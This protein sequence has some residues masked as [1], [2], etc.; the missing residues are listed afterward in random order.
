M[1]ND[2]AAYPDRNAGKIS[3]GY[4]DR[5]TRILTRSQLHCR[6]RKCGQFQF[7]VASIE[8]MDWIFIKRGINWEIVDTQ[9]IDQRLQYIRAWFLQGTLPENEIQKHM[10]TTGLLLDHLMRV[11]FAD[12][13]R[14][15]AAAHCSR[16]EP[17][18]FLR[19]TMYKADEAT[20]Y[21]HFYHW[22]RN[23]QLAHFPGG[24]KSNDNLLWVPT[25]Y[26]FPL[27][28]AE[29]DNFKSLLVN[30]IKLTLGGHTS[31]PGLNQFAEV[32]PELKG[33]VGQLTQEERSALEWALTQVQADL[34]EQRI[35]DWGIPVPST[36]PE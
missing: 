23:N 4:G 22:F 34:D 11:L 13:I 5:R 7:V 2:P 18:K 19:A 36:D 6:P 30:S 28:W 31:W 32:T 9:E 33:L 24:K 21:D 3:E 16:P 12:A 25:P 14:W 1:I 15:W 26:L 17:N 29:H 10:P 20:L 27:T 8:A 35:Q